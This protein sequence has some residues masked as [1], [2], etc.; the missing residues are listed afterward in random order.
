VLK[1]LGIL[2]IGAGVVIAV[3]S[4]ISWGGSNSKLPTKAESF[5]LRRGHPVSSPSTTLAGKA[6]K[7]PRLRYFETNNFTISGS[8]RDDSFMTCPRR[9]K[10]IDGYFGT[11]GLIFADYSAVGPT[12][13]RWDFGLANVTS[14]SGRVFLGIICIKGAR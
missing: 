11:N 2:A 5:E 6:A 14:T 1:K 8:G 13:R 10:V 4:T 9:Y 3:S 7:K 12:I